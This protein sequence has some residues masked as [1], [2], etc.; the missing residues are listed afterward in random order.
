MKRIGKF[1][2]KIYDE[3]FDFSNCK[4]CCVCI[5]DEQANDEDFCKSQH[6]EDLKHCIGCFGCP[7]AKG[8]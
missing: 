1:S 4:E 6:F 2:G 5:T 7:M 8:F 3:N